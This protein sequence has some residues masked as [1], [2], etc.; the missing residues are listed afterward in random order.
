MSVA[1]FLQYLPY[2]MQAVASVPTIMEYINKVIADFKQ[3]KE[4]TAQESA[5]LDAAIARHKIEPWWTP[6]APPAPPTPAP[7]S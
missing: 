4:L 1:L 6:D 5:D 2:L 3:N 7:T